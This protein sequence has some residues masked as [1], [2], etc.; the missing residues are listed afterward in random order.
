MA[1]EAI[2]A[3]G[4]VPLLG[5][6][7]GRGGDEDIFRERVREEVG[8]GVVR[9]PFVSHTVSGAVG[10]AHEEASF[11]T[12]EQAGIVLVRRKGEVFDENRAVRE[13]P[14][15]RRRKLN[16]GAGRQSHPA[17]FQGGIGP[18]RRID[19]IRNQFG[20]GSEGGQVLKNGCLG[21]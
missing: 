14:L 17:L 10:V 15:A 20:T 19:R 2:G 9:P 8:L 13:R 1:A 4:V 11:K 21:E 18:E 5:P 12:A 6:R 7:A 3:A 16:L